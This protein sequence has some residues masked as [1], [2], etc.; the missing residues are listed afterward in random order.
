MNRVASAQ[1]GNHEIV[2][3]SHTYDEIRNVSRW[4]Y[5]VKSGSHPSISHWV[6]ELG[7][8]IDED[9]IVNASE[10]Y[11][12]MSA[13]HPDPT[14][15]LAGIKFDISYEDN[16]QRIVW[17]E[18]KGDYPEGDVEVAI[19]A[20]HCQ[21]QYGHVTGPVCPCY[22]KGRVWH[23]EFHDMNHQVDGMQDDDEEGIEDVV[24]ELYDVS[25][26]LLHTATTDEN[27]NYSFAVSSYGWYRVKV[28]DSN[29]DGLLKNWYSS[30][31]N[32]DHQTWVYIGCGECEKH[33]DFGFFHACISLQKTGPT[34]AL[35][36]QQITYHFVVEN[37][38]D[39]VLHGGAHVY[40]KLL[41]PYGDHEIWEHVVWPG[42][43]YEFDYNYT[44]PCDFCG[45][46]IN[47]AT[48]VGHPCLCNHYYPNVYDNSSWTTNVTC[49]PCT[50]CLVIDATHWG[51]VEKNDPC[52]N[53]YDDDKIHVRAKPGCCCCKNA[54]RAYYYFDISNLPEGKIIEAKF[55]VDPEGNKGAGLLGL[56][57]TSWDGMPPLTWN[58]APPMKE[59]IDTTY[60]DESTTPL[61]FNVTSLFS[62]NPDNI[63]LMMRFLDDENPAHEEHC[64]HTH[65]RLLLTINKCA[66]LSI[67][68]IDEPDPVIAGDMLKYTLV[69]TNNGINDAKNVIITDNLPNEIQNP[70]YSADGGATWHAWNGSFYIHF[71]PSH[72]TQQ[73]LIRGIVSINAPDKINNTAEVNSTTLD[74]NPANNRDWEETT[75]L[76]PGINV[77]KEAVPSVI[78]SGD[79]VTYYVNITNNGDCMLY[80]VT[81]KDS[82]NLSF[83]YSSG[84]DGDGILE[85]GE[86]WSYMARTTI[87]IST[88]NRVNVSAETIAGSRVYGE[89]SAYVTVIHPS[90]SIE[91]EV[92]NDNSTWQKSITIHENDIAYWKIV[93]KNTGDCNLYN[94]WLNDS[95]INKFISSLAIGENKT[96]YWHS[97]Y[98]SDFTNIANVSAKD[99]LGKVIKA[100]D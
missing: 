94:I 69:V 82:N 32:D 21:P 78:H 53:H 83:S 56:Y 64:D 19:K 72:A 33:A 68:K 44:I 43:V 4:T 57:N 17:F 7:G 37:C 3:I 96:I 90:I 8:C 13:S 15:G 89:D 46:L 66:D 67:T 12:Y 23:D 74:T 81:I 59:L 84:D 97:S 45:L 93:V 40:D 86:T 14:T 61:I 65:P 50:Q 73:I 22:I 99:E 9:D 47:N 60:Y 49:S 31:R 35:L 92:S 55:I 85:L 79:N 42:E 10:Y 95:G 100:S 41:N 71:L 27:G 51:W 77:T 75:I 1:I 2:F 11:E 20:G 18:L 63:S 80:N 6:L 87:Y 5:L 36:G 34:Q 48:A 24:L 39:V 25:G 28:A 52:D 26:N 58:N 30:D 16:E 38:G 54:R 29:F 62:S 88:Q 70:Q 91:K 76:H 98:S